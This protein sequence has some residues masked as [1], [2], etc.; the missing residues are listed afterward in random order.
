MKTVY[1]L[2]LIL[3]F[4]SIYS[5]DTKPNILWIITDDQRADSIEAYNLAVDQTHESKLGPV[6]SPNI[7][8][9][10]KEG[11]LFVNAYCNSPACAPSRSSI[12]TGQY[13][14]HSG[15]YGFEQTHTAI[16]E[17]KPTIPEILREQG[18]STALFGKSGYYIFKW[19]DKLTWK[20]TEFYDV[21]VDRKK[22]LVE[23]GFTDYSHV[24]KYLKGGGTNK[25]ES[26]HHGDGQKMGYFT[27][28]HG[29]TPSSKDQVLKKELD[30]EYDILR[31][32]PRKNN[33]IF[34]GV[35]P[36]SADKTLDAY[37]V[38]EFQSF[39]NHKN[40]SYQTLSGRTVKGVNTKAP[41]FVNLGFHFP[42]TPVL[43]P[44]KIRDKFANK[45]YTIPAFD[46]EKELAL[47]PPQLQKLYDKMQ[48][49]TFSPEE[50]QQAIRDYYAFCAFGDELIGKAVKSFKKYCQEQN[51][52]YVIILTVGD[53]GWQL[54]E[55]GIEAKFGPYRTSNHGVMVLTASDSSMFR[56]N[57]VNKDFVEYVD[58]APTILSAAKVDLTQ[59]AYDYLDGYDLANVINRQKPL[60]EYVLGEMNHVI[61]PRAY[62]RSKN[63]AF[64]MRVRSFNSKP[65]T[66]NPP[67]KDIKWALQASIMEVEPALFDLRKD[68]NEQYNVASDPAYEQL[69]EWFREKLGS[70]VLGDKR[71]EV[72][73]SKNDS[74]FLSDFALGADN[75]MM[76]AP[77][78]IIPK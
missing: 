31:A 19:E 55:Q 2:S 24:T 52:E 27:K 46:K 23:K 65:N 48:I 70:I 53:H 11:V 45:T 33:L 56:A 71:L 10:A 54:G 17:A 67:G 37:I 75:K 12:I 61:G 50:K 66:K 3:V 38:K 68:P 16:P 76:D 20:D 15:R 28:I 57:S 1:I 51:Q 69:T 43:P 18:Y 77:S 72:D 4:T 63:F 13:P 5:Q 8:A 44:K 58:I 60:R 6:S 14:H 35:S 26:F 40:E 30:K 49:D 39:L 47:L 42:H 32:Y 59:T 9:L 36:A 74:Y 41:I 22:D 62:I 78:N 7:N 73:W 34:G 21:K 29:S 25:I 64:S